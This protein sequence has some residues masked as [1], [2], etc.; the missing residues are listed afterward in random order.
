MLADSGFAPSEKALVGRA[1]GYNGH[2]ILQPTKAVLAVLESTSGFANQ[3]QS[4][5]HTGG[6]SSGQ[7][8]SAATSGL[9]Q[10]LNMLQTLDMARSNWNEMLIQR[11]QMGLAGG[12][13]QLDFQLSPRKLGKMRISLV[14]QNDRTNIKVQTETSAAASMLTESEGRLA[15]MLEASGLRLGNFSSGLS[16]GFDGKD[17]DAHRH[18]KSLAHAGNGKTDDDGNASAETIVEQ[19]ENLINI[20][21]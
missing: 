16:Q 11:V 1:G 14:L 4:G 5:A 8:G 18:Q 2:D 3:S 19:S 15:Q 12:R 10:N 7:A 20:Q 9:M 21:A 17:A 13:D 6:Q